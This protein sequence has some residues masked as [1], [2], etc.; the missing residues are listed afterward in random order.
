MDKIIITT[1]GNIPSE[2][3][4]KLIAAGCIVIEAKDPDKIKTL[5]FTSDIFTHDLLMSA[6]HAAATD[7]SS[8]RL[9]K[10]LNRRLKSKEVNP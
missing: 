9:T 10:E 7:I 8:D 2:T 1:V 5:N 3:K 6:L 4:K